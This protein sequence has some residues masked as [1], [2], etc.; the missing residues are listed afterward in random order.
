MADS[1]SPL[2]L[3]LVAAIVGTLAVA[4]VYAGGGLS[5]SKLT[6]ARFIDTFEAGGKHEGFRRNHAK[7]MGVTGSFRSNGA[8]ARLSKAV[9]FQPGTVPVLGRFATGGPD[10]HAADALGNV[11]SMALRFTLPNGE[12]WRTGMNNIPVFPATNAENFH[13]FILATAPDKA[14]G[15]PDP[16]K[17][18]AFFA[19]H[20]ESAAAVKLLQSGAPSS[21]FADSTYNSL[22]AFVLTSES[23]TETAVRWAMVPEDAVQPAAQPSTPD[24]FFEGLIARIKQ[25]PVR[26]H[27]VLTLAEDG[28][29]PSDATK[30]WAATNQQLDVGVLTLDHVEA[31]EHSLAR[32]INFDPLVLPSGIAGSSDP[33]LSARSAAYSVSH[34]RRMSEPVSPSSVTAASITA[35][36]TEAP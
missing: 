21:G 34:R 24:T 15:K 2:R 12:E 36:K 14:T 18:G 33:L 8:G 4:F 29:D 17:A 16:A 32:S 35:A 13:A 25:G 5:P 6:P 20:P 1:R 28:D 7:G 30:P 23:G 3:V 9:V 10:P 31:E 22:N 26:W 19:A 27:L 11:R